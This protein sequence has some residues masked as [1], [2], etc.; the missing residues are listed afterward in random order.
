MIRSWGSILAVFRSATKN[1]VSYRREIGLPILTNSLGGLAGCWHHRH[2]IVRLLGR[3]GNH[4]VAED[5]MN[6]LSWE[7][8]IQQV[9]HRIGVPEK[10][11]LADHSPVGHSSG[12]DHSAVLEV[13]S[14]ERGSRS[15]EDTGCTDPTSWLL[16]HSV[17]VCGLE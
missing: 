6:L 1:V 2:R 17:D 10:G 3:A 15:W 12:T 9:H 16:A 5:R 11:I 4:H 13:G 8:H 7:A 14:R